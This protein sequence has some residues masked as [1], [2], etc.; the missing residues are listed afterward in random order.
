ML[1]H[2]GSLIFI[3]YIYIYIYIYKPIS[4]FGTFS[5]SKLLWV[6]LLW[7]REMT[8]LFPK[9]PSLVAV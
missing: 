3:I 8:C 1:E 9:K 7:Q 2:Q 4:N 6:P 5:S